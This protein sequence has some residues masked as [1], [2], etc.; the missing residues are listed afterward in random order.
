MS[1]LVLDWKKIP[2]VAKA[3]RDLAEQ[4]LTVRREQPHLRKT[5]LMH[6]ARAKRAIEAGIPRV[7]VTH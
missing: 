7:D 2:A 5:M 3:R 1:T 4:C 6:L